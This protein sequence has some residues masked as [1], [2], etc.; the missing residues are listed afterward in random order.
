MRN[1]FG[2]AV[3]LAAVFSFFVMEAQAQQQRRLGN[4][5]QA[6]ANRPVRVVPPLKT[7]TMIDLGEKYKTPDGMT[8]NKNDGNIY[9]VIPAALEEGEAPLLVIKPDDT[10]EEIYSIPASEETGHAGT[11]GIAFGPDGN[12]YVADSQEISGHPNHNG[13]LLRVVFEDGKPVRTEVLAKNFV[14]PNGLD[15]YGNKVYFCETRVTEDTP[16]PLTSGIFCFDICELDPENPYVAKPF[17][18]AEDK[19]PHFI[20][21]FETKNPDWRV[22]ANGL[23]FSADGKMY[24]ANFGDAQIYEVTLEE[25]GK[26]VKSVRDVI[27]RGGQ[28]VTSV[29][30][31]KICDKNGLIYFADFA[32]NAVHVV[33][34]KG[35]WVRTLAKNPVDSGVDGALDRCSEVCLRGDKLYV[36]NIDL[37]FGNENNEPHSVSV[38]QLNEKGL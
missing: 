31:L 17:V 30:G 10:V 22:G 38:I 25:D 23:G 27:R 24:V 3:L 32:A 6:S 11:L 4:R 35:G 5:R 12:L 34:I 9:L 2:L 33:N 14:A 8:F 21:H 1:I 19:D 20:F 7:P 29:D 15:V 16:N 28:N 26:T 13:R 37:P 18:S 36:S